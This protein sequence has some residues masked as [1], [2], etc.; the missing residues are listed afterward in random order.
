[1]KAYAWINIGTF[2]SIEQAREF[3][4]DNYKGL[5]SYKF[6]GYKLFVKLPIK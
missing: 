5:C 4:Q 3:W 6:E 1:M 2:D